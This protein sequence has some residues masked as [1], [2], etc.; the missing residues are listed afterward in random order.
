MVFTLIVVI[1]VIIVGILMIIYPDFFIEMSLVWK[2]QF[3]YWTGARSVLNAT[4]G[5]RIVTR[6]MGGLIVFFTLILAFWLLI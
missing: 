1:I 6:I 4:E 5:A 2:N 3:R